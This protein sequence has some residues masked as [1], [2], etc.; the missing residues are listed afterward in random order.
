MSTMHCP[1]EQDVLFSQHGAASFG[2]RLKSK[3][4]LLFCARCR[5]RRA[6]FQE[7]AA[8]LSV[9]RPQSVALG[10]R[11]MQGRTVR[12]AVLATAVALAAAA[13]SYYAAN[14]M[15]VRAAS[16]E[17]A[18]GGK[19]GQCGPEEDQLNHE[20]DAPKAGKEFPVGKGKKVVVKAV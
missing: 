4:H 5:E 18:E 3:W 16:S 20:P 19:S 1:N 15:I 2:A 8:T 6:A 14:G 17:S 12:L 10:Y 13:L 11:P 7:V 9:L